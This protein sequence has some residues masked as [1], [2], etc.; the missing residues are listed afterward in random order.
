MFTTDECETIEGYPPQ[1]WRDVQSLDECNTAYIATENRE[2][3]TKYN[4][5]NEPYAPCG[6]TTHA[7]GNIQ[8][9]GEENKSQCDPRVKCTNFRTGDG[10]LGCL[11]VRNIPD[12]GSN[13]PTVSPAPTKSPTERFV[14]C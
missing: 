10:D 14:F 12:G 1:T 13:F 8:F 4:S 5:P 11:C 6:C 9:W 3:N 2:P 7:F